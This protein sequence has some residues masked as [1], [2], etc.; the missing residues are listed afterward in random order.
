VHCY[1]LRQSSSGKVGLSS[2][3]K[4]RFP[5]SGW[6]WLCTTRASHCAL[7]CM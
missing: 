4:T 3:L 1:Y 2:S 6:P 7:T 5:C